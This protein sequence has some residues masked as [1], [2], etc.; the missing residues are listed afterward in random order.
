MPN[1]PPLTLLKRGCLCEKLNNRMAQ[2]NI[3]MMMDLTV[4]TKRPRLLIGSDSTSLLFVS[5]HD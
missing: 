1:G 5:D 2:A 4:L 3:H